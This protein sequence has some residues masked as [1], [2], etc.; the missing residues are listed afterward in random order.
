MVL[1][2]REPDRPPRAAPHPQDELEDETPAV[3]DDFQ[4]VTRQELAK[5][6]LESLIGSEY[7]RPY[8]HGFFMHSKVYQRALAL[9]QS[10]N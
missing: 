5:L 1:V 3:Y 10:S 4:F 7:L 8:M 9:H 2:P 6:G